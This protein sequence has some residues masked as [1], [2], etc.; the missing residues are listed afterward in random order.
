VMAATT[1][2]FA[3][4]AAVERAARAI[5]PDA[6]NLDAERPGEGAGA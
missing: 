4:T 6:W 1:G 3:D 2:G 5:D